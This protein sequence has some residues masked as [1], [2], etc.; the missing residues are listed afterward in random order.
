MARYEKFD[1]DMYNELKA[2]RKDVKD[3]FNKGIPPGDEIMDQLYFLDPKTREFIEKLGQTYDR[4]VTPDDIAAMAK[5]M[6]EY[7]RARAPIMDDFTRVLGRLAQDF[8]LKAK[9]KESSIDYG[10]LLATLIAG[11]KKRGTKLPGWLNRILGIKDE[12]IRDKLLRRIPG[13]IPGSP[14][15]IAIRGKEAPT[16][17]RMGFKLGKFDLYSEDITKGVEIGI[18]NKLPKTW[19]TVP[20]VNFNGTVLEQEFLQVFEEKLW[21]KDKD[22]KWVVNI[23]QIDQKTDPTTWEQ[24]RNKEGKINAI[25]DTNKVRTSYG[26]NA[27]HSNDAVIVNQYHLFGKKNKIPTASIHDAFFNHAADI[28]PVRDALRTVFADTLETNVLKK[29]LDEMLAR[30]LPKELYDQ[31]LNEMI[32]KGMIPVPGRSVVG[33]K[34]MTKDDILTREDILAPI[35]RSFRTNRYFYGVN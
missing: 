10:D 12:A 20:W 18:A 30:G 11:E 9:P 27:N 2:L 35:D 14:L 33:G 13:Y 1:P 8:M 34:V 17:R 25:A 32:D 23:L 7:M 21:Y 31:Y 24:L 15:D 28:I 26:V 5:I 6:T 3:V 22:G 29:T 4:I 16:K 19:T